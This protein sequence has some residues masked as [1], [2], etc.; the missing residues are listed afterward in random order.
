MISFLDGLCVLDGCVGLDT[1]EVCE[2][3]PEYCEAFFLTSGTTCNTHCESFE[4][5]CVEGWDETDGDCASKLTDDSRRVGNGC[6]MVYGSQ[7]CRC[8][9]PIG[10]L[11]LILVN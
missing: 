9:A 5:V 6:G 8:S 7:I 4:L 3:T 2:E 11:L 10:K 1:E